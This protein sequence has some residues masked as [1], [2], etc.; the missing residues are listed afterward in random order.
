MTDLDQ[1]YGDLPLLVRG[2]RDWLIKLG[3]SP[4]YVARLMRSARIRLLDGGLFK[5]DPNGAHVVITPV[6]IDPD[7]FDDIETADPHGAVNH[8]DTVDLVAWNPAAPEYWALRTGAA[9]VLGQVGPQ[10]ML[11]P[12]VLIVRTIIGWFRIGCQGLVLL[13]LVERERADILRRLDTIFGEDDKHRQE[14][15]ALASRPWPIPNILALRP[16]GRAA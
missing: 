4:G 12:P 11:P 16:R 9:R 2:H 15:T 5:F 8:G 7:G 13:T 6:R 3:V 10:L 1:K 14:L